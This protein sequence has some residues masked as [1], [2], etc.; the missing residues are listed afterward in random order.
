MWS[1]ISFKNFYSDIMS[2]HI[3]Y[4]VTK[5]IK[6]TIDFQS[7]TY[8]SKTE[9][10]SHLVTVK[11]VRGQTCAFLALL[12]VK[13][14]PFS[15]CL[16]VRMSEV[17]LM[18]T[19]LQYLCLDDGQQS[20]NTL[21]VGKV[22]GVVTPQQDERSLVDNF[23]RQG[24]QRHCANSQEEVSRFYQEDWTG[25][26]SSLEKHVGVL[27]WLSATKKFKIKPQAYQV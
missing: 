22:E 11:I 9:Q 21:G 13:F 20:R 2:S 23:F 17:T 14:F 15:Y 5:N 7:S 27:R 26:G 12:L 19:V 4:L 16:F 18:N 1:H 8:F 10:Q 24:G 3:Q 6:T 25:D